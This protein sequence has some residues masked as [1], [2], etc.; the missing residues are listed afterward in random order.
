M[1][2][3]ILLSIFAFVHLDVLL[4]P[5]RHWADDTRPGVLLHEKQPYDA[6]KNLAGR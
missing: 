3:I 1:R 4:S 2:Y 5:E 6:K